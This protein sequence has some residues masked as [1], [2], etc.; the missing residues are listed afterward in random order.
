MRAIRAM[1][2][3]PQKTVYAVADEAG[4]ALRRNRIGADVE[5]VRNRVGVD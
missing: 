4:K 1:S 2:K 5:S 3:K